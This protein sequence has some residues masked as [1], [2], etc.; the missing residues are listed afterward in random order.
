MR[1][2]VVALVL[3]AAACTGEK[4]PPGEPGPQGEQGEQGPQG[5]KGDQGD[6]GPPGPQGVAGP[7][8]P[9]GSPD[10]AQQIVNKVAADQPARVNLRDITSP[11][12]F[13]AGLEVFSDPA[14][15]NDALVVQAATM[16]LDNF[17]LTSSV[18]LT[19]ISASA[20]I[21]TTGVG[22]LLG[23]ARQPS[24]S[25]DL[26]V[27]ASLDG[28]VSAGLSPIG[29]FPTEPPGFQFIGYATTITTDASANIRRIYQIGKDVTL[30]N[31]VNVGSLNTAG[32]ATLSLAGVVPSGTRAA[33]VRVTALGGGGSA[34]VNGATCAARHNVIVATDAGVAVDFDGG[35]QSETI[36][37]VLLPSTLAMPVRGEA[38]GDATNVGCIFTVIG[39]RLGFP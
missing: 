34:L 10:T 38:V 39:Y 13:V 3:V 18:Q 5:E 29:V 17:A 35:G 20:D 7:P 25:Y 11:A 36:V 9:A 8:G 30:F 19:F 31:Q 2:G 23:G 32:T 26:Y 12:F 24:A 1:T 33:R 14:D 4:G 37:D 22:G 16:T 15:L 27:L 21:S 6:V 28:E